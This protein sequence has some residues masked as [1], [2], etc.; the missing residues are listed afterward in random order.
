MNLPFV[1]ARTIARM[2]ST[3]VRD[4]WADCMGSTQMR[5]EGW[6]MARQVGHLLC[7]CSQRRRH[8]PQKRL[9][10]PCSATGF[11]RGSRHMLQGLSS[12]C[13]IREIVFWSSVS[14]ISGSIRPPM[15]E[16]ARGRSSLAILSIPSE[17]ASSEFPVSGT[18]S[19]L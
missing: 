14:R 1:F 2:V 16:M 19:T 3:R 13:W 4:F 8:R 5:E 17:T 7:F 6:T 10:H 18:Y 9:V 11:V 12:R 15:R